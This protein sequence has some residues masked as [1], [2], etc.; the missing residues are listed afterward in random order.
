MFPRIVNFVTD[1]IEY[2]S[3]GTPTIYLT[4][5]AYEQQETQPE[6]ADGRRTEGNASGDN[7]GESRSPNT[8]TDTSQV[9]RL[10][11]KNTGDGEMQTAISERNT[12]GNSEEQGDLQGVQAEVETEEQLG[13]VDDD[14][15]QEQSRVYLDYSKDDATKLDKSAL[16]IPT[17]VQ[18]SVREYLLQ[19][20]RRIF[21]DINIEYELD[22]LFDKVYD[23]CVTA[24]VRVYV[25]PSIIDKHKQKHGGMA[26]RGKVVLSQE[27]FGDSKVSAE[28]K[29]RIIVHEMIHTAM[30]YA[31]SEYIK[32]RKGESTAMM[33]KEMYKACE[34]IFAVHLKI[35]DDPLFAKE[36]G[37]KNAKEL[38]AELANREFVEKLK[39]THLSTWDKLLEAICHIFG[40]NKSF[41]AYDKLKKALD[42]LLAHPDNQLRQSYYEYVQP[43]QENHDDYSDYTIQEQQRTDTLTDREVLEMA[44]NEIKVSDLTEAENDALTIFQDR[45]SNLKDLQD[46][47]AEQGRLYKEQQF[48]EK[49]DRKAAEETL[50]RMHIL[51]SQ[52]KK[53][54]AE[55][56][57]VEEKEVLK[58][59]LKKARKLVETQER[60]RAERKFLTVGVTA[61]TMQRLW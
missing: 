7:S 50:N 22:V 27:D 23:F 53:A 34:Q 37:I 32:V 21:K 14:T 25:E 48:G 33:S 8:E 29:A 52:I 35:K 43:S 19:E 9:Q 15:V 20:I 3:D 28:T 13:K 4:E 61:E 41:S 49:V 12:I 57:T 16:I 5:D 26:N 36:Y 10:H 38:V 54:T 39:R 6:T 18:L 46:E 40:I 60:A 11:T 30:V 59:V 58:R 1:R 44:A 31:M 42:V 24:G 55:V 2:D 51:D 56:L 17:S 45:L 47:R